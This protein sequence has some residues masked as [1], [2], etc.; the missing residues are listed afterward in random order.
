MFQSY[1]KVFRHHFTQPGFAVLDFGREYSP[2][3]LRATMVALKNALH[4]RCQQDTGL[5]LHYQWLGTFDQQ[6]TT[7]FPPSP[8][9]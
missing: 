9:P 2:E 5:A 1:P 6:E 4:T 3:K 8:H 7:K